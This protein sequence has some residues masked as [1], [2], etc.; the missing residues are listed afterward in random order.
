MKMGW[1][2]GWAVPESW[3]APLVGEA[4][5]DARHTF[6][7]ATPGALDRLET[8]GPFDVVVGYSLG[9]ELLLAAGE[10]VS[11][12]G[13]IALLAPVLAFPREEDLGGRVARTQVKQLARWLK[14]DP[15]AAL[16]DFY[17]RA[18][19]DVTVNVPGSTEKLLWGLEQLE[20][21]RVEPPLPAGWRAWCGAEDALLDA[22]RLHALVPEIRLVP[23]ATH[24]PA[25]LLCSLAEELK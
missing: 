7:A 2:M 21:L 18:G 9:A 4:F 8:A 17:Q 16:A 11:A 19:L 12:W 20:I 24:H 14:R 22:A 5:P 10:R 25:K 13:R 15:A 6:V 3:F 23:G 1:L